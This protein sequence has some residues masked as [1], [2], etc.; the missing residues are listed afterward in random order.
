[1][2][3]RS[4]FYFQPGRIQHTLLDVVADGKRVLCAVA[5]GR[6]EG[7]DALLS[8]IGQETLRR[9]V[10]AQRATSNRSRA[11]IMEVQPHT[12]KRLVE[13]ALTSVV[14]H[15]A[16][17]FVTDSRPDHVVGCLNVTAL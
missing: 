17:L 2:H 10:E 12:T 11:V 15:D 13:A 3:I 8:P 16:I 9:L 1:M 4:T 7:N 6:V 14:A 5:R